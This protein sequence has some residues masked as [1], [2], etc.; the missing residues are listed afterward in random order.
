[1]ENFLKDLKRA[2]KKI[3]CFKRKLLKETFYN[4]EAEKI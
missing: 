2:A 4:G 3:Q 1:M